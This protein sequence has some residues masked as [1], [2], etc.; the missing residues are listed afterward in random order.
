MVNKVF[1]VGSLAEEPSVRQTAAGSYVCDVFLSVSRKDHKTD[2][3]R[4]EAWGQTAL[5]I[6]RNIKKG[7][8][9][10]VEGSLRVKKN[11]DKKEQRNIF[12]QFVRIDTIIVDSLA[13]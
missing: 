8:V 9:L 4:C 12:E 6:S 1:L 10:D 5:F 2:Y 11:Y 13:N 3:I 7:M